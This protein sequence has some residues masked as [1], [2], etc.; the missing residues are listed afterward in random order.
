MK[1]N[2]DQKRAATV[3]KGNHLVLAPAGSGKTATLCSRVA[4]L[5][6]NTEEEILLL[7]FTVKA[8]EEMLERVK[9]TVDAESLVQI[10]SGT[11]HSFAY[12]VM[13]R[14]HKYLGYSS[15]LNIIDTRDQKELMSS[16]ARQMECRVSVKSILHANSLALNTMEPFTSVLNES[17][18]NMSAANV[19]LCE[20][21][22][23]EYER[24]KKK[25]NMLD[26]DDLLVNLYKL[27]QIP[28]ARAKISTFGHILLDEVQDN[29]NLQIKIIEGLITKRTKLFAVGDEAQSIYQFR[30]ANR[31][32]ILAFPEQFRATT[33]M[34]TENYRSTQQI[35]D[36]ANCVASGFIDG[37]K[38][39]MKSK[40][41]GEK[42][43][44]IHFYDESEQVKLIVREVARLKENL[45]DTAVI[46]R[47]SSSADKLE[48]ALRAEKIPYSRRGTGSLFEL[49]VIKDL[50]LFLRAATSKSD[51]I[52]WRGILL[53]VPNVGP[54]MAAKVY[55]SVQ[56]VGIKGLESH[57]DS[58]AGPGIKRLHK[59]L[60]KAAF[61]RKSARKALVQAVE[62]WSEYLSKRTTK[63][64]DDVAEYYSRIRD[65]AVKYTSV[66]KFLIDMALDT[67]KD[68]DP[69]KGKLILSTIHS[70]KGMGF[71]R[72]YVLNAVEGKLPSTYFLP[73]EDD[74]SY[75]EKVEEEKRLFY[76]A[77]TRARQ[78]LTICAPMNDSE[79]ASWD[80]NGNLNEADETSR[81]RFLDVEG[82]EK[83]YLE[84]WPDRTRQKKI[85]SLSALH[86][87]RMQELE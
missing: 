38:V 87:L 36:L 69:D 81:T 48:A 46:Y 54:S 8:A 31:S 58:K 30:G 43:R 4:W 86:R 61:Y 10:T 57:F 52:A 25:Y 49:A 21:V 44:Y 17:M 66:R 41:Q 24:T 13:K 55:S 76:V 9:K 64:A 59:Y 2:S 70:V 22:L 7:T 74:P 80:K 77:L 28:K 32:F 6:R 40:L 53:C 27:L 19:D 35:L 84:K 42:P 82:I 83:T 37:F 72:V 1:L 12:S 65:I 75:F 60:S 34:L 29:N 33:T 11:F 20:K 45:G 78:Y 63:S 26:F 50:L 18:K 16:I 5:A 73:E 71:K 56:E 39:K 23:E 85:N 51:T 68:I 79:R 62:Y 47:A 3:K 67:S 15:P 14:C